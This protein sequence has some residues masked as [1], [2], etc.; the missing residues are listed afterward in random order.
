VLATGKVVENGAVKN[1]R[2]MWKLSGKEVSIMVTEV[3]IADEAVGVVDTVDAV[4]MAVTGSLHVVV[5][6]TGGVA[7]LKL[8]FSSSLLYHEYI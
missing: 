6:V 8:R 2:R 1:R 5:V 4:T 3:D 7:T